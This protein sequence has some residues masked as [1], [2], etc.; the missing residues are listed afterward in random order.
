[1]QCCDKLDSSRDNHYTRVPRYREGSDDMDM[2]VTATGVVGLD[3][4]DDE[5]AEAMVVDEDVDGE[6]VLAVDDE[7][8]VV[9]EVVE[10]VAAAAGAGKIGTDA[11]AVE[12]CT[13][14]LDAVGE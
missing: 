5:A 2:E 14:V 10:V 11:E 3:I 9:V 4:L 6:A 12:A 7:E 13:E 8:E 1:M